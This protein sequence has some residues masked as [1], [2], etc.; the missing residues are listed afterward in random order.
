MLPVVWSA[1]ALEDV[2]G[3]ADYISRD[4]PAAA[5]RLTDRMFESAD[6]LGLRAQMYRA[7]RAPGTREMIVT[8]NYIR[9]YRIDIDAVRI[10]RLL[11]ATQQY[12]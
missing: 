1:K 11:H 9:V 3:V 12:P 5:D 10:V 8:P 2:D 7:G 6:G 4:N